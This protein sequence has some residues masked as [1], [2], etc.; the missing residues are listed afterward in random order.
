MLDPVDVPKTIL[1]FVPYG[2]ETWLFTLR[3]EHRLNLCEN[4]ILRRVFES[5]LNENGEHS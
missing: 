2:C 1:S 4:N 3:E 5:K